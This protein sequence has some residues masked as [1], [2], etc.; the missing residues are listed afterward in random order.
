MYSRWME[1]TIE[2][3][4]DT[5]LLWYTCLLPPKEEPQETFEPIVEAPFGKCDFKNLRVC[6]KVIFQSCQ[7]L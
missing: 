6:W 5:E 2:F 4:P 3:H 7:D 1:I